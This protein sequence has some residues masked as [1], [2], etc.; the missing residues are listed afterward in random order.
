M[1]IP[2]LKP[3]ASQKVSEED[4]HFV[5]PFTLVGGKR[6]IWNVACDRVWLVAFKGDSCF[7][8]WQGCGEHL[9]S[10][11]KYIQSKPVKP[12]G[13]EVTT[14]VDWIGSKPKKSELGRICG[15]ALSLD[16]MLKLLQLVPSDRVQ[17]WDAS[18][19]AWDQP[20]LGMQDANFRAVIMGH[21]PK[22]ITAVERE[23]DPTPPERSAFDLAMSLDDE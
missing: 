11:L 12:H 2:D 17:L 4:R 15:A 6:T 18:V 5:R 8:R 9:S 10:M 3:F 16:R 21:D 1:M 13:V 7:E 23:F 19:L 20:C 14:L 22:E